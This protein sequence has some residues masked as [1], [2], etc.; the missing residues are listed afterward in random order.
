MFKS[1]SFTQ[2]ISYRVSGSSNQK[3]RALYVHC[4]FVLCPIAERLSLCRIG[5]SGVGKILNGDKNTTVMFHVGP[6]TSNLEK[7]AQGK[8]I[9]RQWKQA[10]RNLRTIFQYPF[11]R[12]LYA[13]KKTIIINQTL[14]PESRDLHPCMK[15]RVKFSHLICGLAKGIDS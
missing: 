1:R 13:S 8:V 7:P 2:T 6:L 11:S 4:R 12:R 10:F 15:N 14:G 9:N 5:C 3:S